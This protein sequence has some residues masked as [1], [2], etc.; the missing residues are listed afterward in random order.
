MVGAIPK[1]K[2]GAPAEREALDAAVS[3]LNEL[4]RRLA[5]LV[6]EDTRAYDLVTAAY[7]R[8]KATDEEKAARKTAIQ[9]ALRAATDA[10]LQTMRAC[11]EVI[12]LGRTIQE[13]S[14]PNAASD[15]F[16]G[17]EMAKAGLRGAEKN[18]AIN[19]DSL[20]DESYK[21][22]V[23]AEAARLLAKVTGTN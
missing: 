9:S 21:Q 3:T 7:K 16:V 12:R 22:G 4:R 13:H 1:T 18:V 10:P 20:T 14:N 11:A 8:P 5:E 6:D 2:T 15:L 17:L 23:T 19:L